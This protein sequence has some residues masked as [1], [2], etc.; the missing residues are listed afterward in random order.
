V[1]DAGAL[2]EM[3]I[4]DVDQ[5]LAGF[6]NVLPLFY[7]ATDKDIPDD[8]LVRDSM[9]KTPITV[10]KKTPVSEIAKMMKAKD[11]GQI[12]VHG[13]MD[14]LVGMVYDLDLLSVLCK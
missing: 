13:N 8:H 2:R 5:S 6:R 11:F 3:G 14:E 4:N 1:K 10:F 9:V 12:P 7:V